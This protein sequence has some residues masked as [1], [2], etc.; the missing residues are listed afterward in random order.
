MLHWKILGLEY[1]ED[2]VLTKVQLLENCLPHFPGQCDP[3][4]FS[5]TLNGSL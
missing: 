1:E 3:A 2:N 4:D 5:G